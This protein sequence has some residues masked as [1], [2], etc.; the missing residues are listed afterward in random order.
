MRVRSKRTS[1]FGT[2]SFANV[3]KALIQFDF[4]FRT[5]PGRHQGPFVLTFPCLR[6][7]VAAENRRGERGQGNKEQGRTGEEGVL[8]LFLER[9]VKK[10][11]WIEMEMDVEWKIGMEKL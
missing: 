2:A 1:E 6:M 11:T 3:R 7:K 5:S 10:N 8:G 9:G 4:C